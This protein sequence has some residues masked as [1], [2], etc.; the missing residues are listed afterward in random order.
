MIDRFGRSIIYLRL[1]VT[2]LCNL[3]CRYCMPEEGVC[4]KE[5]SSMLTQEETLLAVKAAAS[6]GIRKVR[7]TGGEPLVKPN[8]VSICKGISETEGI[9]EVCLTTNGSGFRNSVAT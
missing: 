5:H 4:K 3:R 8:I 2:E 7:V 6:V 1:S 9:E